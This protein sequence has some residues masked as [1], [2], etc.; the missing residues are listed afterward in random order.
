MKHNSLEPKLENSLEPK[1]VSSLEQFIHQAEN[2]WSGLNSDNVNRLKSALT[3]LTQSS[4]KEPW[5]AALFNEKPAAK[6]L[7]ESEQHRFMLLAHHEPADFYRQPHDH[8]NG[9]VLYAVLSGTIAMNT[10]KILTDNN[11]NEQLVNRGKEVLAT[12]DCRVFLPGDIH[13]THCLSDNFMQFR[14][15]SCDFKQ[16]IKSGRMKR[17]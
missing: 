16:E 14:F 15:T 8:G 11:G 7:Y 2:N 5:L 6:T 17:F 1:K 10:Y 4:P 12:G 9:W 13:H 3:A